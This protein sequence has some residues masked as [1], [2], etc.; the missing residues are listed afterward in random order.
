MEVGLRRARAK[1]EGEVPADPVAEWR[2]AD[3]AVFSKI[4]AMLGLDEVEWFAVA[5][6][7][8]PEVVLFFD[9]MGIEIAE[10]WGLSETCAGDDQP[11]GR[12][13]DRHGRQAPARH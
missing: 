3:E 7:T 1:Q 5:A 6:P 10:L 12:E 8:P 11:A 2:K 4:R 13:P 9:A